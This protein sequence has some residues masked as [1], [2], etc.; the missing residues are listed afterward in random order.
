MSLQVLL[1]QSRWPWLALSMWVVMPSLAWAQGGQSAAPVVAAV[2]EERS[3]ANP[4]SFVGSVQPVR[5]ASI[6]SA[7]DGRVVEC[8]IEEGDRVEAG[9]L[10]GQLLTETI[11]LEVATAKAELEYKKAQLEE[12]KNGTRPEVIEAARAR[13]AA[14]EA[15]R[16]YLAKRR[17]RFQQIF[18]AGG[19]AITQ[20]EYQEA[21]AQAME[22]QEH[23]TEATALYQEAL[24]GPRRETIAQA[25]AQVKMQEAVVGRL[26][27]Q[28]TKHTVISR[29]TG[30]VVAKHS[31]IG[32][33]VNRGD[34][35]AEVVEIDTVEVV[36]HVP[37]QS[38]TKLRPGA[39][40]RVEIP[41]V[42]SRLFE[43][44]IFTTVPQADLRARTFPVKIR[45]KN[46]FTDAGPLLM[47]GMY[48]RMVIPIGAEQSATMVP[49]DAIVLG[50]AS[51]LVYVIDGAST[52]GSVG[53]VTP[54]PVQLGVAAGESIQV[55]GQIQPGQLVV[56]E[57]N[58][59]LIPGQQVT[60]QRI[61][62]Q[63]VA[64]PTASNR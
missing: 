9:Q 50:Q 55:I 8:P 44:T 29:F 56:T 11:S 15:Q 58:E 14:A 57:G 13:M 47:P 36:A 64:V 20:D 40:V 33:W 41:A 6:G 60:I 61:V 4:Q 32:Q 12:L 2:A 22:A 1:W 23:H 39:S 3:V 49:K 30:Y 19:G 17:D 25:E 48:A 51:R 62:D 38:A 26:E 28:L 31:E 54:V 52:P 37:E 46:E 43:G 27:D 53:R 7:V 42:K 18:E 16:F 24:A 5:R 10:L 59:R 45:I 21:V 34:L 35:I 63:G